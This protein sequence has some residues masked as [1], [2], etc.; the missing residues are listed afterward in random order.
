MYDIS[1]GKKNPI[2]IIPNDQVSPVI[3]GDTIVWRDNRDG[4]LEIYAYRL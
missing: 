4:N 1:T 3:Y 2:D